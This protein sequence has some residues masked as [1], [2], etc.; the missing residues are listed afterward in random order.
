M[1]YRKTTT[2]VKKPDGTRIERTDTRW[3]I[4]F[5]NL[6]WLIQVLWRLGVLFLVP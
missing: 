6:A 3:Q 4:G 5:L 2:K 1:K